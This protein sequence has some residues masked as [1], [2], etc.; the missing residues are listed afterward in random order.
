[1]D[2]NHDGQL[3]AA[4]RQAARATMRETMQRR[5]APGN[6]PGAAN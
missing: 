3:T 4:E 6:A 5:G 1:M 2:T